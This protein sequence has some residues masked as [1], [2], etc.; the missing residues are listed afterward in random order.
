M[1][2]VYIHYRKFCSRAVGYRVFMYTITP[3]HAQLQARRN[4]I[5]MG[6]VGRVPCNFGEPGDQAYSNFCDCFFCWA[7]R[8]TSDALQLFINSPG[9]QGKLKG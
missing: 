3:L 8:V 7:Q 2:F 4:D 1:I 6:D 5:H 9:Q